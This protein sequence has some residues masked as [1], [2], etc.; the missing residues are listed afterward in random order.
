MPEDPTD[1]LLD[2][3]V[4]EMSRGGGL[5]E[6]QNPVFEDAGMVLGEQGEPEERVVRLAQSLH[7]L[8][9]RLPE[10]GLDLF[11]REVGSLGDVR[12]SRARRPSRIGCR[13]GAGAG[14]RRWSWGDR[15]RGASGG[16]G[17]EAVVSSPSRTHRSCSSSSGTLGLSECSR[18]EAVGSGESLSRRE[19]VATETGSDTGMGTLALVAVELVPSGMHPPSQ[20]RLES[21]NSWETLTFTALWRFVGQSRLTTRRK[22]YAIWE[23]KSR[24]VL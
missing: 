20:S 22:G 17:E 9:G 23:A 7:V 16:R 1:G 24:W 11:E 14:R 15:A 2:E 5:Q 18:A 8:G 6:R 4:L 13:T 19:G 10:I 12:P 3:E 21:N